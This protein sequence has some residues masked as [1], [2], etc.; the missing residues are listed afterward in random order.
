MCDRDIRNFFKADGSKSS[1]NK[2]NMIKQITLNPQKDIKKITKKP[3]KTQKSK[4][5]INE[6]EKQKEKK[7]FLHLFRKK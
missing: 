7:N 6:E 5:V 4:V 2:S 3:K 1:T